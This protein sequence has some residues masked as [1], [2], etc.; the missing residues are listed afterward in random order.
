MREKMHTILPLLLAWHAN[1]AIQLG[2][3]SAKR[4]QY[5]SCPLPSSS[6]SSLLSHV[7]PTC[8]LSSTS[9]RRHSCSTPANTP[10]S[11]PLLLPG[12]VVVH[13]TSA[14]HQ[15]GHQS[16]PTIDSHADTAP[17]L[18]GDLHGGAHMAGGVRGPPTATQL[19]DAAAS[20]EDRGTSPS[21]RHPIVDADHALLLNIKC[22]WC[23][24][25]P[26]PRPAAEPPLTAF[27]SVLSS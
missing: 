5:L 2:Y 18:R 16:S 3:E 21:R 15:F 12:L 14:G 23:H 22:F 6:F 4:V 25:L 26:R 24:P 11:L 19:A 20:T 8:M 27:N 17:A 10:V 9:G 13:K 1:A 7:G